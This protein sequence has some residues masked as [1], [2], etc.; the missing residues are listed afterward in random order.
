[1]EINRVDGQRGMFVEMEMARQPASCGQMKMSSH[2]KNAGG[3]MKRKHWIV[4]SF[5]LWV[6]LHMRIVR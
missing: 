2:R 6:I 4:D 3:K 5:D 1:L